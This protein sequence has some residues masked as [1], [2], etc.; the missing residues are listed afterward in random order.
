MI[1]KHSHIRS[2]SETNAER[3][4]CGGSYLGKFTLS[5]NCVLDGP[6]GHRAKKPRISI[7]VHQRAVSKN[8]IKS[9]FK[10]QQV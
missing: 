2:F 7:Y 4:S 8:S 5:G 10:Q 3:H 1:A 6:Y 9:L